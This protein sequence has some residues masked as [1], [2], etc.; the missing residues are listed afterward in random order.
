MSDLERLDAEDARV[1]ALET[2]TVAGHTCKIA[3]VDPLPS[4]TPLAAV[5]ERLATRLPRVPRCCQCLVSPSGGEGASG[6]DLY[7]SDD[8]A[9]SVDAHVRPASTG[10]D[11]PT[12]RAE[13]LDHVAAVM[14]GRLDRSRP[15]WTIDVVDELE[16]GGWAF[17]WTIHHCM[18][19]GMTSMRWAE[20][21]LWD[22]QPAGAAAAP[23]RKPPPA[24]AVV[25]ARWRR[26][27]ALAEHTPA[28]MVRELRPVEA[29]SPFGGKI[30]TTR[31]VAFAHCPIDEL[32]HVE[33][34]AGEGVTLNDVLLAVVGGGI[35]RWLVDRHEGVHTARVKVPVSMHARTPDGDTSGNRDSFMFV[36]VPLAEP[37]PMRRLRA[38]HRETAA[39]KRRGDPQTL[40]TVF[41]VLGRI[42]ALGRVATRLTMS[43]HEFTLNVSN[44]PGPK[45][46]QSMFGA[47]VHELYSLAE[48]APRHAL[49]VSAMSLGGSMFIGFNTDPVIVP[50]VDELAAGV[51]ASLGEL[52]EATG[53]ADI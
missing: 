15:L 24:N 49:R 47:R 41:E 39:R 34:A 53:G 46:P 43:P 4:G 12:S 26:A 7:W 9:F 3:I 21:L 5:R 37:D 11:G 38:V 48:I 52:L 32:R 29:R 30:G 18:C 50:A 8:D 51:E 27:A 16:D 6:Q 35:R 28:A 45:Q 33:K 20:E 19:D 2:A 44:V 10:S 22:E 17:V 23:A 40:Y 42:P 14:A 36:D 25:E 31:A 1:L 13:L